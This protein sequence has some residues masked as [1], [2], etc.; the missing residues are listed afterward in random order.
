LFA[1]APSQLNF[2]V[3]DLGKIFTACHFK[4]H[5]QSTALDLRVNEFAVVY[6]SVF[7]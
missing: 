2:E 5:P 6:G 4:F 1:A 7:F 3:A